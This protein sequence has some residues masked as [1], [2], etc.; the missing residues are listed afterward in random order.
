MLI[1]TP[2]DILRLITSAA[3]DIKVYASYVDAPYPASPSSSVSPDRMAPLSITTATTTTIVSSPAASTRRNVKYINNHASQACQVGVE[4]FDSANA[5]ELR[6]VTLLPG[7]N[8]AMTDDSEWHH[9]DAQNGEYT[10]Q[11]PPNQNLGITGTI[12]ESMPREI[13][14]EV[15]T[16]APASGTLLL[17]AIKLRAGD[18]VSTI[19]LW[20]ATTAAGTPTNYMAGLFDVNR[21]QLASSANKL[22]E[23][24][25]ANSQKSFAMLTPYRVPVTGTYF[26]GYFMTAT[27]VA[28]L[29]GGTART[30]GQL[31]AAAP[32]IYGTS[33]TALTTALP[34]PAAA[35]TSTTASIY[36]AIR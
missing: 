6:E 30:G 35:I 16:A 19:D 18:L 7:E 26:V 4:I 36:A 17:Q 31:N 8:L 25:A 24:W 33:S 29:K 21:N 20:S 2:T 9:R 27:T 5:V 12:A 14:P 32:I 11:V 28:T 3:A 10:Y 22:T 1:L 23:A 15:N 13:C 34:N